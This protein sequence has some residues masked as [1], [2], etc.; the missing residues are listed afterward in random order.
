MG[1]KFIRMDTYETEWTKWKP[2]YLHLP[3]VFD[4]DVAGKHY[5]VIRWRRAE[6]RTRIGYSDGYLDY[7]EK[8]L[9]IRIDNEYVYA[10][11]LKYTRGAGGTTGA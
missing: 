6:Y 9:R 8:Q 1:V 2:C 3:C 11:Q 7:K 10:T 4:V 5:Y